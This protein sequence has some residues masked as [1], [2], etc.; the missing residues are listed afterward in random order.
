[1]TDSDAFDRAAEAIAGTQPPPWLVGMVRTTVYGIRGNNDTRAKYPTRKAL[2]GRLNNVRRGAE[3]LAHE[4]SGD[5]WRDVE[6]SAVILHLMTAGF[7]QPSVNALA[8]ILPKLGQCAASA[9][10][11][12]E[13]KGRDKTFPN[14]DPI[15][16]LEQCAGLVA[17]GWHRIRGTSPPHTSDEVHRACEAV[18]D[19]TGLTRAHFGDS[20]NGWRP[21]IE[22]I[23]RNLC[24]SVPAAGAS[25][26]FQRFWDSLNGIAELHLNEANAAIRPQAN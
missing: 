5:R 7:D 17:W 4:F 24:N 19:A 15:S 12:R 6:R 8:T 11:I 26:V 2:R 18:W 20:L 25:W 22:K 10:D 9:G 13:G 23:E 1:M 21:H 16:D 14:P 3:L